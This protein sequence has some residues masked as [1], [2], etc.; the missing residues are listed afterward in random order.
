MGERERAARRE[1]SKE[2]RGFGLPWPWRR[3]PAGRPVSG[4]WLAEIF[5]G[6]YGWLARGLI[7]TAVVVNGALVTAWAIHRQDL[8]HRTQVLAESRIP[9]RASRPSFVRGL[10]TV[11]SPSFGELVETFTPPLPEASTTEEGAAE[12][13]H[14]DEPVDPGPYGSSKEGLDSLALGSRLAARAGVEESGSSSFGS[15]FVAWGGNPAQASALGPFQ[16]RSASRETAEGSRGSLSGFRSGVFGGGAI[17]RRNAAVPL[18]ARTARA[19]LRFANQ[20]SQGARTSATTDGASYKAD[21]AFQGQAVQPTPSTGGA[22]VSLGNRVA[23]DTASGG[24]GPGTPASV[25]LG[26]P[27]APRESITIPEPTVPK[28]VTPWQDLLNRARAL[29][30]S[31]LVLAILGF[32]L[33]RSK[34][35]WLQILGGGL[36]GLAIWSALMASSMGD[37]IRNKWG[38]VDQDNIIKRTADKA[39][40]GSEEAARILGVDKIQKALSP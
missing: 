36:L 24:G 19:Q 27:S 11:V 15:R 13:A 3:A 28:N 29:L 10:E 32:L 40:Q 6:P 16:G 34:T 38:Q 23:P 2:K 31:A 30:S 21:A 33:L 20:Q 4:D 22:G 9:V 8:S 17:L 39:Q 7:G 14:T 35:P 1:Q 12:H 37:K 18:R 25:S 26:A 5:E